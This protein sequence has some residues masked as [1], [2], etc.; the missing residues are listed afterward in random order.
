[1]CWRSSG[2][3]K[4]YFVHALAEKLN[5]DRQAGHFDERIIAIAPG[6][7]AT[8]HYALDVA[9]STRIVEVLSKYLTKTTARDI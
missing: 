8:L 1:M 3:E 9:I 5:Q 4:A 2:A 7:A 6:Q